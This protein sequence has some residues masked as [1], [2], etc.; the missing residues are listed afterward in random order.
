[1]KRKTF[2]I[3][4]I[5]FGLLF[6]SS[7]KSREE[8]VISQL[9]DLSER[10]EKDS[11][12]FDSNDWKNAIAEFEQIHNEMADCDFTKEELREIGRKEGK[13]AVILAKEGAKK[14]GSHLQE[15]MESIGSF[16]EG[17][18]EGIESE[19]NEKDFE[20]LGNELE[21]MGGDFEK[22]GNDLEKELNHLMDGLSE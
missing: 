8:Q 9:D 5:F 21:K 1:M 2:F 15:F 10:V 6:L 18:K 13:L 7:C 14:V 16:S 4:A 19:F 11:K 20:K 3:A 22:M 12:S 17:L